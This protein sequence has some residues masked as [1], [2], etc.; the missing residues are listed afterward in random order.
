MF[1]H[2]LNVLYLL[3]DYN[4]NIHI[5]PRDVIRRLCN[6]DRDQGSKGIWGLGIDRMVTY[7]TLENYVL[8]YLSAYSV[9]RSGGK[10][11]VN[12]VFPDLKHETMLINI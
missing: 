3:G 6:K 4:G 1:S 7:S 9:H 8:R 10:Q 12:S 2:L 5:L 11:S